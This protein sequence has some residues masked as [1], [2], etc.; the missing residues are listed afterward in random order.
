MWFDNMQDILILLVLWLIHVVIA[1]V[2][3]FPIALIGRRRVHWYKWELLGFV[4]PFCVWSGLYYFWAGPSGAKGIGN[5]GEPLFVSLAIILA[6]LIR[7]VSGHGH[8]ADQTLWALGVLA[9]QCVAAA[10]ICFCIPDLGG[11]LG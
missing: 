6:A 1:A 10:A 2:L 4:L 11:S 5:I 9:F 7:V 3:V 8:Q